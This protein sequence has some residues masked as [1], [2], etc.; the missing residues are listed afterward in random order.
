MKPYKWAQNASHRHSPDGNVPMTTRPN[1]PAP[2]QDD[3]PYR[4]GEAVALFIPCYIDQFYPEIAEATA[5]LST[6]AR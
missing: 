2:R 5:R 4:K 3:P 6:F 1:T